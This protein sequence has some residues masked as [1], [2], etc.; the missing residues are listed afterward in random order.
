MPVLRF[1]ALAVG[2]PQV[3]ALERLDSKIKPTFI[4][5]DNSLGAADRIITLRDSLLP[6]RSNLVAVP[7]LTPVDKF[8]ATWV[9]T[10]C[11][12]I[13]DELKD[14]EILGDLQCFANVVD[15]NCIITVGYE[16]IKN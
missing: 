6:D 10:G 2:A 11:A 14:I 1:T 3:V 5:V 8:T 7:V 9:I 16:F 12:S 4:L 13:Q 15:P